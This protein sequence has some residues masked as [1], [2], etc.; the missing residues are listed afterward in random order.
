MPPALR[1]E[2]GG[3]KRFDGRAEREFFFVGQMQAERERVF[4]IGGRGAEITR[5]LDGYSVPIGLGSA[6]AS[7]G[8][9]ASVWGAVTNSPD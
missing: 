8:G 7:P 9:R 5:R 1:F 4:P 2:I 6:S 3:E